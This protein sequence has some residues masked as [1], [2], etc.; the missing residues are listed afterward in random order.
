MVDGSNVMAAL[1]MSIIT[2]MHVMLQAHN[3]VQTVLAN[4]VGLSEV[5]LKS[6][7]WMTKREVSLWL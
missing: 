1:I 6:L 3:Y 2:I 5:K 7:W 4:S